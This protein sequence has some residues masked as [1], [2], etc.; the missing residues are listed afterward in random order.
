G[1][2]GR[3]AR[4]VGDALEL[5]G[6]ALEVVGGVDVGELLRVQPLGEV[7]GADRLGQARRRPA[8]GHVDLPLRDGGDARP[9]RAGRDLG[10]DR[11]DLVRAVRLGRR[12]HLVDD[13]G[14]VALDDGR[15]VDGDLVLGVAAGDVTEDVGA[16]GAGDD[17]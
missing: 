6:P 15:R 16:A 3:L 5:G 9:A 4:V 8:V 2:V 1:D 7:G 10:D 11:G 13:D 17:L 14:R 12:G